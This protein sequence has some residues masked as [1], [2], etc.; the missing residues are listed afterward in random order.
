MQQQSQNLASSI[1]AHIGGQETSTTG[2]PCKAVGLQGHSDLGAPLSGSRPRHQRAAG[3]P[4][5]GAPAAGVDP[6]DAAGPAAAA[7]ASAKLT[8]RT[9]TTTTPA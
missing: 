5:A 4:P 9:L 1:P 8:W 2:F 3:A 7:G 6:W